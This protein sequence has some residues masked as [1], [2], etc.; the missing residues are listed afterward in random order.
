MIKIEQ[1]VKSVAGIPAIPVPEPNLTAGEMVERAKA[2]KETIRAEAPAAEKRGFYSEDLH[3]AFTTG[4]F[5]RILQPRHFGGYEFDVPA[6]FQ[7]MLEIGTADPGIGW[8]LT[9]GSGHALQVGSYFEPETQAKIFG[10]DGHF[11]APFSLPGRETKPPCVAVPDGKG[12]RIRGRWPYASGS[13]Y[14]THLMGMAQVGDT[15]DDRVVVVVPRA[16]CEVLSDW[17]NILGLKAS[18]SNT[19]VVEDAWIPTDFVLPLGKFGPTGNGTP[20]SR[21]HNNP[22]YAGQFLGF[23]TGELTVSQLGAARASLE[24]YEKIIRTSRSRFEPGQLKFEHHDFQRIFG[25][26]MSMILAAEAAYIRSGEL[27]MEDARAEVAGGDP[28]TMFKAWRL[29]GL[30]HQA[31]RL[32]WEAGLE[33]FR[34]ASSS[35]AVD[36]QPM[37]RYF[38]DLATF[39]NNAFHQADFVAPEIARAYFGLPGAVV[40]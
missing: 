6:Y 40:V 25:L 4:G 36:G 24:E 8:G 32:A 11:V 22:L 9:L 39:K 29:M 26:S 10:S 16:Q 21:F 33:L 12:F 7:I 23:A 31:I 30:Q 14:C 38:R 19:V 3:Q 1:G 5:Y 13:P 27:Y 15:I 2:L 20:G 28:F 35:N 18:G 17:G 34:A 37:Q